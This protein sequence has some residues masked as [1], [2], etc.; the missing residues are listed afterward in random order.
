MI[1]FMVNGEN[2]AYDDDSEDAY[3]DHDNGEDYQTC[4]YHQCNE[5]C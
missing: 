3:N 4:H 2:A 5:N 1:I